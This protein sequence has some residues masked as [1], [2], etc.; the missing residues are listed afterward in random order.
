MQTEAQTKFTEEAA[1]RIVAPYGFE[2][3]KEAG[4]FFIAQLRRDRFGINRAGGDAMYISNQG[5]ITVYEH[6]AQAFLAASVLS[7]ALKPN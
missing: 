3:R 2:A 7:T 6:D 5:Q 4:G 1:D